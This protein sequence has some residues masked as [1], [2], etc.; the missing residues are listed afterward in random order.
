M[1]N[2]TISLNGIQ[3]WGYHG[4]LPEEKKI[5]SK[6]LID[7]SL[8]LNTAKAE[9][10]DYIHDTIDYSTVYD[11]IVQEFSTPVNLIEHLG[12]K[13][14]NT[15]HYHFPQLNNSTITIQ[16]LSPPIS[17]EIHSASIMLSYK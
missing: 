2:S 11:I 13:I 1:A 4:C 16:K 7:I 6:Y 8:S 14:L 17:G 5:G 10:S 12:R 3:L 9:K 15:I